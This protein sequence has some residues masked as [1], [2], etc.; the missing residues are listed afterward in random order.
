MASTIYLYYDNNNDNNNNN[1]NNNNN[2]NRRQITM[3]RDQTKDQWNIRLYHNLH[4]Q[5]LYVKITD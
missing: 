5:V 4:L 2:G 3:F 1:N